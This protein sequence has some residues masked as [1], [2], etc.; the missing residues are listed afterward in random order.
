MIFYFYN[1]QNKGLPLVRAMEA[2]G[3]RWTSQSSHAQAIFS[4]SDVPS[5]SK[6]LTSFHQRGKKIFLYPH[7]AR[8]NLFNDFEGYPPFPHTTAHF[9]PAIGHA[10]ILRLIGLRHT[11]EVTGWYLCPIRPFQPRE[12][13][14]KILFAPI[15]PN[16]NGT[17]S[18]ADKKINADTMR[19]LM[20]LVESGEI[21]LTIRFLRGLE[22][23]GLWPVDGV[24]YIE[25]QPDQS[26]EQIDAADVVVS[27]QTF[28]HIA[29]ARGVPTVM[30]GEDVPP[31]IGCEEYGTFQ[32]VRNFDR[33]KHLLMYP[34]DI[35]AEENTP[36][37]LER[38]V[39]SDAEI[40]DWRA[41]L[42]GQPFDP[43]DFV[44]LVKKYL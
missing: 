39:R 6:S 38:A 19:K 43:C 17:L 34:L 42:I 27:H 20:P 31:R 1:H 16:S 37:L 8:P 10:E 9:I 13:V 18:T 2:A 22:K 21:E 25:G 28:A 23:N 32:Y 15:H 35:L 40:A 36:A 5:R 24:N 3:W 33:Y 7:A 11:F 26:F 14:R 12:Q 4:D 30:M 41:R 44:P 29:V